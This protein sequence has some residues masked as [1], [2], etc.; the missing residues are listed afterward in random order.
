MSIACWVVVGT[1]DQ[2]AAVVGVKARPV[3]SVFIVMLT[4]LPMLRLAFLA[5]DIASD[6]IV[7]VAELDPVAVNVL[8]TGEPAKK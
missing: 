3:T 5:K 4:K 2:L 6:V 8:D 7:V 1:L